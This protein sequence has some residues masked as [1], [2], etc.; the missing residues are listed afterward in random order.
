MRERFL[1]LAAFQGTAAAAGLPY[2]LL[3][4]WQL[5]D[6][7]MLY[8]VMAGWIGLAVLTLACTR[9][10]RPSLLGILLWVSGLLIVFHALVTPRLQG[11]MLTGLELLVLGVFAAFS[12]SVRW[13]NAWMVTC[14]VLYLVAVTINP[15][16]LG[17][18]LAPIIVVMLFGTTHVVM[19]LLQRLGDALTHDPLTGALN[20][21]GLKTHAAL[22]HSLDQ[23][24]HLPTSLAFMD[25]NGF[26]AFNDSQG[27]AM[28]DALLAEVV[29][30]LTS[31]LRRSDL[32]ARLGGD[33]F[34]IVMAA[35]QPRQALEILERIRPTL[36]ISV[37]VGVVQWDAGCDLE[38]ALDAADA[39]M[40]EQ[41]QLHHA[42]SPAGGRVATT[43][44]VGVGDV[45]GGLR[46]A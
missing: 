34:V 1:L 10:A 30:S 24:R 25:L 31:Q 46:K 35:T 21:N 39:L 33:E 41:K 2:L 44:T 23:R 27:H 13:V 38:D 5:P 19:N 3:P 15:V 14:G 37:S 18:W 11:Q 17:V 9:W 12:F 32:V 42:S 36:P 8:L 29:K 28:G 16:N 40:Y 43:A 7:M 4:Q 45:S 26:K 22:V 20:R 6:Q